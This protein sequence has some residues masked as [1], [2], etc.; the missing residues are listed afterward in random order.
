[1]RVFHGVMTLSEF[2]PQN[3]AKVTA[4]YDLAAS[5]VRAIIMGSA[6]VA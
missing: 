3:V 2:D 1:M 4:S 6:A 5:Q